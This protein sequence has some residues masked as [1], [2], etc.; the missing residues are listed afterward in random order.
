MR[1]LC[2]R[3]GDQDQWYTKFNGTS[4]ASA[5]VAGV[6]AAVQSLAGTQFA[7]NL[8]AGTY[9]RLSPLQVRNL[10]MSTGTPQGSFPALHPI[11]PIPDALAAANELLALGVADN[12]SNG[13]EDICDIWADA[14]QDCNGNLVI[15]SVD[16][17]SGAVT[18]CDGN[19]VD[20]DCDA[21]GA[22]CQTAAPPFPPTYSCSETTSGLCCQ[23]GGT[24]A[25]A[26]TKCGTTDCAS[27][28]H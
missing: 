20:D 14:A 16:I 5:I 27:L 13:T 22:C 24:F 6:S 23:K 9:Q 8:L 2:V 26:G 18:D 15:D 1:G 28:P 10:L 25:G 17:V 12:N 7:C 11:G 21:F 4:S 3:G 19:G